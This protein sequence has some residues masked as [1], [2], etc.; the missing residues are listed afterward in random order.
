MFCLLFPCIDFSVYTTQRHG[1]ISL[2]QRLS[3]RDEILRLVRLGDGQPPDLRARCLGMAGEVGPGQGA[4]PVGPVP[5]SSSQPSSEPPLSPPPF[6]PRHLARPLARFQMQ[7]GSPANDSRPIL[8]PPCPFELCIQPSL[9]DLFLFH[10]HSGGYHLT[11]CCMGFPLGPYV[12]CL[13]SPAPGLSP[14]TIQDYNVNHMWI[15]SWFFL[16]FRSSLSFPLAKLF[17]HLPS[18]ALQVSR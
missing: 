17:L 10:T 16:L 7:T 2:Y 15:R 8:L 6:L 13:T 11:R 14:I 12:S 1:C 4:A 5:I 9:L 18:L 3:V